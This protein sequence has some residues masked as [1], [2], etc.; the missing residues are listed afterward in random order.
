MTA[1][2][3]LPPKVIGSIVNEAWIGAGNGTCGGGELDVP[4]DGKCHSS[5][6]PNNATYDSYKYV[7]NAPTGVGCA[8]SGTST[9]SGGTLTSEQTICCAP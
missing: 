9:A 3:S 2:R 8:P 4:A 6:A 1:T 5:N 7:A